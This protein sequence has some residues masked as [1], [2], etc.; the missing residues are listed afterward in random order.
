MAPGGLTTADAMA[1]ELEGISTDAQPERSPMLNAR[2]IV[3]G[4]ECLITHHQLRT[5][6]LRSRE[7][8]LRRS[9]ARRRRVRSPRG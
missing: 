9:G 8:T 3:T 4:L 5:R 1:M 2:A 7:T 6:T